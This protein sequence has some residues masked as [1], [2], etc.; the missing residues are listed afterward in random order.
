HPENIG[1]VPGPRTRVD[2]SPRPAYYRTDLGDPQHN[3]RSSHHQPDRIDH[4]QK[5]WLL[6]TR[7]L[8][9]ASGRNAPTDPTAVSASASTMPETNSS[10]EPWRRRSIIWR[11]HEP[12][13][14]VLARLHCKMNVRPSTE[15]ATLGRRSSVRILSSFSLRFGATAG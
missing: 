2:R 7:L 11:T 5:V 8:P 13:G 14:C 3:H 1:T 10:T 15:S 6:I 12:P 4:F 9:A